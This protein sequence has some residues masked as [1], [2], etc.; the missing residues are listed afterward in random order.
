MGHIYTSYS[1]NYSA[2]EV[3]DWLKKPGSW[4]FWQEFTAHTNIQEDQNLKMND[5]FVHILKL[6][7]FEISVNWQTVELIPSQKLLFKGVVTDE[8]QAIMGFE[9]KPIANT[10]FVEWFLDYQACGWL[11][12][13]I[14]RL[15]VRH[16]LESAMNLA[17]KKLG[18]FIQN[19]ENKPKTSP[20][21]SEFFSF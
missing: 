5:I 21:H 12:A 17:L 15:F 7:R 8:Y 14:D 4:G 1:L 19:P 6:S 10:C 18:Q 11:K 20:N 9:L 3:F 13:S 2:P 16:R